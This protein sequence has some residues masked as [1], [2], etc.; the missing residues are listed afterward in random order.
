MP[1]RRGGVALTRSSGV[2]S[3]MRAAASAWRAGGMRGVASWAGE[4][5][6]GRL[7]EPSVKVGRLR[8]RIVEFG[9]Q[10]HLLSPRIVH[11]AGPGEI[12]YG[13]DQLLVISVVRNGALHVKSFLEHY[14]ALGVVHCVFLD[15]GS[16]DGTVDLL[17]SY[18]GVTVLRTDVPYARFENTMKRYL[19]ERFSRGRWNLCADI[20]ELFDYPFS[21]DLS[22]SRFLG[23][24]SSAVL[25]SRGAPA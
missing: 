15:N 17:R 21:A 4:K 3:R 24:E 2:G 6:R 10:P 20:D 8:R 5:V 13:V 14:Q 1:L 7:V 22:L 23:T 16:T 12:T 11:V 9:I 19:A 25:G 18:P